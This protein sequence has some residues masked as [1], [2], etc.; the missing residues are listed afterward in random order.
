MKKVCDSF[1]YSKWSNGKCYYF[2]NEEVQS[3]DDAQQLC[4]D[5]FKQQGFDNGRLFEPKTSES[6]QQVYKLAEKFSKRQTLT[7]WLGLDDKKNEGKYTYSSDGTLPSFTLPWG[8]K[9]LNSTPHIPSISCPPLPN[10]SS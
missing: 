2:H 3:F 10:N 4:F 9:L 8:S 5:K 1:D 7:I 6:L